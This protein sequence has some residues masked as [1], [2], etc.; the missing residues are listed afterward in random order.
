MGAA[1]SIEATTPDLPKEI[2][3]IRAQFSEQAERYDDMYEEMKM[4]V[5]KS[6]GDLEVQERNLMS[7]AAKNKIGARRAA[8]RTFENLKQDH[9]WDAAT[10]KDNLK[11]CE[12][13]LELVSKEIYSICSEIIDGIGRHMEKC[14][15]DGG[16]MEPESEVFCLKMQGDY[17]R[18]IA[19]IYPDG[20]T[21]GKAREAAKQ[22]YDAASKIGSDQLGPTHPVFLGLALN[23]SVF[24]YEILKDSGEAC[25]IAKEAFDNAVALLDDLN[26]EHYKDATLIMQLLRDNLTLW[27]SED[28]GVTNT[29]EEGDPAEPTA[30]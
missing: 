20:D 30:N 4:V 27:T 13:K 10:E 14:K 5:E 21:A 17:N 11:V 29:E 24:H 19:E 8:W 22:S 16:K 9:N 28:V 2:Y 6:T 1:G 26:E 23:R 18:Y 12:E 7:V 3:I 15:K 25:K